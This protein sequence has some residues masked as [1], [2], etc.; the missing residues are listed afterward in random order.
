MSG[1]FEETCYHSN[2]SE[3]TSD[4]ANVKNSQG[5]NNNNNNNN[6][7]QTLKT[8]YMKGKTVITQQNSKCRLYGDIISECSK[9]AE[10][11]NKSR[12]DWEGDSV[13]IVKE[14]KFDHTTKRYMY[15]SESTREN[16]DA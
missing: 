8:N 3:K 6:R 2:S 10:K 15:E 7:K 13:V 11:V 16:E 5:V 4:N 1:R 12:N 14:S 9:L